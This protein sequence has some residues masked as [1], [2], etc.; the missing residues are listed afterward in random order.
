M[1]SSPTDRFKNLRFGQLVG[2]T[3]LGATI[4]AVV[5]RI[6]PRADRLASFIELGY[7]TYGVLALTAIHACGRAGLRLS[8]VLGRPPA[9][10]QPWV[11]TVLIVPPMMMTDALLVLL[12]IAL[13]ARFA[14]HF[15]ER[16]LSRRT[17]P[18]F[19]PQA[20]ALVRWQLALIASVIAPAVEEFV[21]RGLVL[22][23]LVGSRG[24]WPGIL[25]TSAIFALLHPQALLG[26]FVIGIVLALL[27][28]SSG[29]LL[30]S[31]LAHAI[32]NSVVSLGI[33]LMSSNAK[34]G[35]PDLLLKD[36]REGWPGIVIGLVIVGSLLLWIARPLVQQARERTSPPYL[37][38]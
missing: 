24:L 33:L 3:I 15:T 4:A 26:A 18:D 21:F 34:D 5:S 16:M 38:A 12:T 29:S 6:P 8:E 35:T 27:Y 10:W 1:E 20:G 28:L 32:N 9:A 11:R 22:R 14:P 30:L 31:I 17:M 7:V 23:R 19:L 37:G 2:W 36:L 13:G 25:I